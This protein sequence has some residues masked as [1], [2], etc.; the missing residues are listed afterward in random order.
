MYTVYL[1]FFVSGSNL[2]SL[3][4][5]YNAQ[6][7][8]VAINVWTIMSKTIF[9]FVIYILSR[10]YYWLVSF[11]FVFKVNC[12]YYTHKLIF[13]M[14]IHFTPRSSKMGQHIINQNK[15]TYMHLLKLYQNSLKESNVNVNR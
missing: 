13:Y 8:D 7:Y 15:L 2:P 6:L 4:S 3:T 5:F 14:V 12:L 10:I 9:K 11:H 1:A